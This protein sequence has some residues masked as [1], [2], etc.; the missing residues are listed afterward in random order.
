MSI[1]LVTVCVDGVDFYRN[2]FFQKRYLDHAAATHELDSPKNSLAAFAA[3]RE[4]FF[5]A[6][7]ADYEISSS[8]CHSLRVIE[9][10]QCSKLACCTRRRFQDMPMFVAT[11][12]EGILTGRISEISSFLPNS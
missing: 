4:A 11:P 3:L 1:R 8:A 10:T 6:H 9:N 7:T 2:N 5:S 12:C